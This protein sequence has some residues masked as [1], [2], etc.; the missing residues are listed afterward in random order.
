[1]N[2]KIVAFSLLGKIFKQ[3]GANEPWSDFSLGINAVEYQNL[4]KV[5][6]KQF[7]LNGWFT[8]QSVR[9]TLT[10]W[11]NLLT[12]ENLITWLANYP[13]N[14]VEQKRIGIIM[15]GNI[16]LVG[17][18]D[19]LSVVMSGHVAVVKMSS[20]DQT[21]LPAIVEV[22]LNVNENLGKQIELTKGK[23]GQIDAMIATGSNNSMNYF[24][25][26]FGHLPHVFRKNRTSIAVLTGHE[27]I[28]ELKELGK[29]IFTYFGLGCR[30]ISQ[31]FIP[32]DFELN[33]FFEAIVSYGEV[34]NHHKYA[35]NYDYNKAIHLMNLEQILDNGFVLLKES[36]DLFSP[37]AMLFYH[38]YENEQEVENFIKT[39]QHQIQAVVGQQFIPFGQAQCPTLSDYADG[40]DTMRW[41]MNEL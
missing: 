3:L 9:T 14:V 35:N 33:R 24:E 7:H 28:E 10:A 12:E 21:L 40:V 30:N 26:Y 37:L 15:A 20:D 25:S 41:L 2:D 16:P 1:M 29:D 31:L 17:F 4:N 36:K 18:H 6:T 5:I 27:S 39:N 19:F 38:R 22:L 13:S 34:V 23:L 11:G 32:K 8:D